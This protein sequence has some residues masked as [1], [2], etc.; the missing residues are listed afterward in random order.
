MDIATDALQKQRRQSRLGFLNGRLPLWIIIFFVLPASSSCIAQEQD[1]KASHVDNKKESQ[2]RS[3]NKGREN[4]EQKKTQ[5]DGKEDLVRLSKTEEIWIN[6]KTKE[7][8][9]GG[10][11]CLRKGYLEMFACPDETKEHESIVAVQCSAKM[12]HAA[13][14]AIGAKNGKPVEFYP[15]YRAATGDEIEVTIVYKDADGKEK[16]VRAQEWIQNVKTKKSM[17]HPWVFGGS[18]F[19]KE[20]TTGEEYYHGDTG[21]FICVS[22]FSI[23][24]LDIPVES[25]DLD[26]ELLYQ[27]FT[28]KIPPK[29]TKVQLILRVKKKTTKIENQEES[30]SQET[31]KE[32]VDKTEIKQTGS[33]EE[34]TTSIKK[35]EKH[36]EENKGREEDQRQIADGENH[37]VYTDLESVPEK[38]RFF[39]EYLGKMPDTGGRDAIPAGLEIGTQLVILGKEEIG[40]TGY[41]D[42]LP[43]REGKHEKFGMIQGAMSFTGKLKLDAAKNLPLKGQAEGTVMLFTKRGTLEGYMNKTRITTHPKIH[44]K[45]S[46]EGEKPPKEGLLLFG[47]DTNHFSES[48]L[49]KEQYLLP[50]T[51]TKEKFGD[52]TLHIEFMIPLKPTAPKM[53]R[54]KSGILLQ[55][56]YKLHLIDSF[57][58][59]P[60]K[61]GCGAIGGNA[62]RLNLSYPPLS[63]QTF[64][65]DFKGA[66]YDKS[67]KKIENA[68]VTIKQ[69]GTLIH[70]DLELTETS[71]EGEKE[72]PTKGPLVLQKCDDPI[73]YRNIW[74]VEK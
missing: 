74:V 27:A 61:K 66:R 49:F 64:D 10:V 30:K 19:W 8:I 20:E 35:V 5:T 4:R 52:H 17:E 1:Q 16:K 58:W 63:W 40:V 42:G 43:G 28:E 7:V 67:G 6:N 2:Q 60:E 55:G 21:Y 56:R 45:S 53:E 3:T 25:T 12:A 54:A 15:E 51:S 41:G 71:E 38:Y 22:N 73:L 31:L 47:K 23:A 65:I 37:K 59:G 62:P 50:G 33:T 32:K 46:T 39:G 26:D 29:R 36:V 18:G 34:K 70:E 13:L 9:I 14:L 24:T 11:V 44:R 72:G 48:K 68:K 69:N 57:G